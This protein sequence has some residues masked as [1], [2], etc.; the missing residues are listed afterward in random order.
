MKKFIVPQFSMTIKLDEVARKS[1]DILNDFCVQSSI[2]KMNCQSKKWICHFFLG[3]FFLGRFL[4]GLNFHGHFPWP[5]LTWPIFPWPSMVK[6]SLAILSDNL[7]IFSGSRNFSDLFGGGMCVQWFCCGAGHRRKKRK[8]RIKWI[9]EF[10]EFAN[11]LSYV[12][13]TRNI[14]DI[15]FVMWIMN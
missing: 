5:K 12:G 4:F 8:R 10:N 15:Y 13:Q 9:Y 3:Y 11:W 14:F 6:F 7:A 2:I 1:S